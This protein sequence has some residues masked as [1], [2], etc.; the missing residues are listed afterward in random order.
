[1]CYVNPWFWTSLENA[2]SSA[3][4]NSTLEGSMLLS[5]DLFRSLPVRTSSKRHFRTEFTCCANCT[6]DSLPE[7][8]QNV[9]KTWQRKL[10]FV[11]TCIPFQNGR[12]TLSEDMVS[13][14]NITLQIGN[15]AR[16][17]CARVCMVH[18]CVC[19]RER[20]WLFTLIII[21]LGILVALNWSCHYW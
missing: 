15:S 2:A 18:V 19:V 3:C 7:R 1:M 6:L 8:N 16:F 9:H 13:L 4:L 14:M 17:L 20:V 12:D 11:P 10:Q 5:I 21:L